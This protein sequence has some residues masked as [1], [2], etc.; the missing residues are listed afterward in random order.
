MPKHQK[1][2]INATALNQFV[3]I[4]DAVIVDEEIVNSSW[5]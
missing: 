4:F 5:I 1:E 2:W 3:K